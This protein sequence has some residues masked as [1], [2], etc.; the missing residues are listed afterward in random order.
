MKSIALTSKYSPGSLVTILS[1]CRLGKSCN[2]PFYS[3]P[4]DMVQEARESKDSWK[5]LERGLLSAQSIPFIANHLMSIEHGIFIF[6]RRLHRPNK[7]FG[8][9]GISWQIKGKM[10][11]VMKVKEDVLTKPAW[12][13]GSF[14]VAHL[15]P[16]GIVSSYSEPATFKKIEP[17]RERYL[18]CSTMSRMNVVRVCFC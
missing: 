15:C 18:A 14:D 9:T 6:L 17:F 8:I 12:L 1:G 10:R 13:Y 11:L 7:R 4:S 16:K 2:S 5:P 3:D